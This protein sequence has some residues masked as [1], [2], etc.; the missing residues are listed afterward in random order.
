MCNYSGCSH[1]AGCHAKPRYIDLPTAIFP[2]S[3][4][5]IDGYRHTVTE[6]AACHSCR[7]NQSNFSDYV[8]DYIHLLVVGFNFTRLR[9]SIC[10]R[11]IT[12]SNQLADCRNCLQAFHRLAAN[13][14]RVGLTFED[15]PQPH[16]TLISRMEG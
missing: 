3:C 6:K 15:L 13:N 9:C 10:K 2:V 5:K 16:I 7:V 11:S 1:S 4:I 8:L 14:E 12:Q